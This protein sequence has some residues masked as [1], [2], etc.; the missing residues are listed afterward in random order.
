MKT[1]KIRRVHLCI[2]LDFRLMASFSSFFRLRK[3]FLPNA[4]QSV[5]QVSGVDGGSVDLL[6]IISCSLLDG[7]W[8]EIYFKFEYLEPFR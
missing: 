7:L 5:W 1:N 3:L 6:Q 2:Y 8:N 4:G